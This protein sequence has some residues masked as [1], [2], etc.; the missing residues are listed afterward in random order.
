MKEGGALCTVKELV[1]EGTRGDLA[2]GRGSQLHAGQHTN[3]TCC[4]RRC[5]ALRGRAS[6]RCEDRLGDYDKAVAG[7]LTH[8]LG[9]VVADLADIGAPLLCFLS[10]AGHEL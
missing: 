3:D 2:A 10:Q 7:R 8:G 6:V 9:D 4:T 1:E 5:G